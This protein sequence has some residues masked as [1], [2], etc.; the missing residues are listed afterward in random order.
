MERLGSHIMSIP[1]SRMDPPP[2]CQRLGDRLE[3]GHILGVLAILPQEQIAHLY[4]LGRVDGVLLP[5]LNDIQTIHHANL[6]LTKKFTPSVDGVYGAAYEI[7]IIEAIMR[8]FFL[9]TGAFVAPCPVNS[10]LSS[11]LK[12][13][14]FI[15][16]PPHL[17]KEL[18][19]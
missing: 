13:C 3:Y 15:T 4:A 12:D 7:Y 10:L 9:L 8:G 6:L 17:L 16:I 1:I 11:E 5:L 19:S 2:L 14:I 18:S